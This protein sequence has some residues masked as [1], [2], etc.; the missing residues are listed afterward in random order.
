MPPLRPPFASTIRRRKRETIP[1]AIRQA[2][3]EFAQL[4][5]GNHAASFA[6]SH[7]LKHHV[8][9]LL[10]AELPPRRRPGRPG[11][12]TVNKAQTL[13]DDLRRVHPGEPYRVLWQQVYPSVIEGWNMMDASERR[14]AAE[15]LRRRV[16]WRRRARRRAAARKIKV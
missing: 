13:L 5:Q 12:P 3:S 11:L 16:Q 15:E 8:A 6:A 1:E 7:R 14:A 2:V 9:R 10:A 4:L